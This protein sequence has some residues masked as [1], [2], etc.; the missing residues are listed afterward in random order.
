MSFEVV[1]A[2]LSGELLGQ[3]GAVGKLRP[4][5]NIGFPTLADVIQSER[6]A[7]EWLVNTTIRERLLE[8]TDPARL[9]LEPLLPKTDFSNTKFMEAIIANNYLDDGWTVRVS[10]PPGAVSLP[11]MDLVSVKTRSDA[12]V[13]AFGAIALDANAYAALHHIYFYRDTGKHRLRYAVDVSRAVKP[14]DY[15]LYFI[16]FGGQVVTVRDGEEFAVELHFSDSWVQQNAG[17]SVNMKIVLLPPVKIIPRAA[18]E[19]ETEGTE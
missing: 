1:S 2:I 17:A 8:E 18:S 4:R 19:F 3:P 7:I 10:V 13:M 15:P 12:I 14:Q 11:P 6:R 5:S 9:S 16:S